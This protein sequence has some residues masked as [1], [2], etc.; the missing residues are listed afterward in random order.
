MTEEIKVDDEGRMMM[1]KE[2]FFEYKTVETFANEYRI[3][4]GLEPID[5]DFRTKAE[6]SQMIEE[7]VLNNLPFK[8]IILEAWNKGVD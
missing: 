3:D 2:L 4:K 8:P 5:N 1:S 6:V 7:A